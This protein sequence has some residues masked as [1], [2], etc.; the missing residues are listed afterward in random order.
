MTE[1]ILPQFFFPIGFF[2]FLGGLLSKEIILE[3]KW[4]QDRRK[5]LSRQM[6]DDVT[7]FIQKKKKSQTGRW[8]ELE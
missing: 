5:A 8:T 4:S 3:D 6:T 2:K 7:R 1:N